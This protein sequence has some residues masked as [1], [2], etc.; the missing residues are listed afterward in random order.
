MS[1]GDVGFYS[2]DDALAFTP[3]IDTSMATSTVDLS[4]LQTVNFGGGVTGSYDPSSNTYFDSGG[5]PLSASDLA[6]YGAFTVGNGTSPSPPS[7]GGGGSPPTIQAQGSGAS[8]SGLGGL[9]SAVT[10]GI[11]TA[12]RPTIQTP[13]QGTLVY[14][15]RTGGYTTP[16][17]LSASS[18]MSPL[19]LLILGG[20]VI[21]LVMKG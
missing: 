10:G 12:M 14:N 2:P 15:P 4:S 8:L 5:N 18:T 16:A 3:S 11:V 7:L 19:I 20:L 21:Y 6:Q 1:A 13:T 17:A 9:F